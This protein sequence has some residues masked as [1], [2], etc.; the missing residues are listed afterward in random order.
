MTGEVVKY[1]RLQVSWIYKTVSLL[2]IQDWV[3]VKYTR[4]ELMM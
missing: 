2:N 3:C 1:A 4:L